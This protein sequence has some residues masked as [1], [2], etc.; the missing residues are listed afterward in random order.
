MTIR[1]IAL[2]LGALAI[3]TAVA[4]SVDNAP[5]LR[6]S[7]SLENRKVRR[8]NYQGHPFRAPAPLLALLPP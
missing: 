7:A 4:N 8:L 2:L 1:S 3:A 5:T 6:A